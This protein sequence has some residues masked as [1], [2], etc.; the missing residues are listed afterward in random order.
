MTAGALRAVREL[1]LRMPD[2]VA[3]VGFDD[4]DWTTLVDPPITVVAQPVAELGRAVAERLLARLRGDTGVPR[5]L[6]LRTRLVVRGSCGGAGREP[7]GRRAGWRAGRG[8]DST[9]PQLVPGARGKDRSPT[10]SR[11]GSRTRD[12]SSTSWEVLPGRPNVVA[13]LRGTGGDAPMLCGHTDVV[14]GSEHS[15]GPSCATAACT[16]AGR[17]TWK[18]GIAAA[19]LAVERIARGGRPPGD[20]VL[21]LVVDEEW[22]SAGAEA[23]VGRHVPDAAIFPEPSNLDVLLEHGGFAWFEVESRGS[24]RP[25]ATPIRARR[26]RDARAGPRRH[27]HA[28][29]RVR[30][31]ARASMG[32]GEHPRVD[33]HRRR[34]AP[35]VSRDVH[36]RSRALSDPRRD[37]AWGRG[38]DASDA[39]AR[40][41]PSIPTST[42]RCARSSAAI[43]SRSIPTSRSR[44]RSSPPSSRPSSAG[45]GPSSGAR[46][47]GWTRVS[48]S[49]GRALR[50]FGPTGGGEH[51]GTEWVD[52]GSV[53]ECARV[54]ERT[55]RASAAS[56]DESG[57][58]A[59]CERGSR[60]PRHRLVKRR[61]DET[62]APSEWC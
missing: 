6:R 11:G 59:G 12:S 28:R 30:H 22:L 38:R 20:L 39:R 1:G 8:F 56:A 34:P 62:P 33:D 9:N 14:R 2:D 18:G 10:I 42:C 7:G 46:S 17:S 50:D 51:T 54:L 32:P 24:R 58:G 13:T 43:R 48:S 52:I 40:E 35:R 5:E 25:G 60:A 23:L 53:E 19:V 36:R 57:N 15:S 37:L 4:L 41:G 44:G 49:V 47:A 26:H 31:E 16:A 29:S 55:A 61:A 21:A 27:P 3:L 45:T